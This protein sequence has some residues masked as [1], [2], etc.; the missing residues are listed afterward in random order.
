MEQNLRTKTKRLEI[1]RLRMIIA[2]MTIP[3][4]LLRH[5]FKAM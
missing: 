3:A 5:T 4:Y 1:R 2:V